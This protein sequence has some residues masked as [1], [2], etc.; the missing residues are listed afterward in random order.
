M[1]KKKNESLSGI[2]DVQRVLMIRSS[3]DSELYQKKSM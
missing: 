2:L 3:E 1:L